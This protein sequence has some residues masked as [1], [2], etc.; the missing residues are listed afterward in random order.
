MSTYTRTYFTY[1]AS[2]GTTKASLT[3]NSRGIQ[4][5]QIAGQ[6]YLAQRSLSGITPACSLSPP[7]ARSALSPLRFSS[8]FPERNAAREDRGRTVRRFRAVLEGGK[9]KNLALFRMWIAVH[10][11]MATLT[12]SGSTCNVRSPSANVAQSEETR[13]RRTA[14]RCIDIPILECAFCSCERS[15]AKDGLRYILYITDY[16][17]KKRIKPKTPIYTQKK[18]LIS[19]ENLY[20]QINLYI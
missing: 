15:V 18:K 12:A 4:I 5:I 3:E 7:H 2:T 16:R 19:D 1:R 6:P 10:A 14:G 13:S 8:F 11:P 20:I 9:R 17:Y